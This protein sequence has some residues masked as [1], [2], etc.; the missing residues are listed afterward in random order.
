MSGEACSLLSPFVDL[1]Y[2]PAS[3]MM[4]SDAQ[5]LSVLVYENTA[6]CQIID[7]PSREL[8]HA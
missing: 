4:P 1:V 2:A 3:T 7:L 6:A 5:F 8:S